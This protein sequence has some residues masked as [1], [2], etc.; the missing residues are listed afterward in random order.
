MTS[1]PVSAVTNL[2]TP[3]LAPRYIGPFNVIK[4]NEDAAQLD[5]PST[6]RLHP[7]FYVGRLK[8]YWPAVL[9]STTDQEQVHNAI[10]GKAEVLSDRAGV[11][12][13][14][15]RCPVE[16]RHLIVPNARAL[17]ETSNRKRSLLCETLC[18]LSHLPCLTCIMVEERHP[19][20]NC[21]ELLLD[22]RPQYQSLGL[23][24]L[25]LL[26]RAMSHHRWWIALETDVG[27]LEEY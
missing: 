25:T 1:I 5:I 24:C 27:W 19:S 26:S 23:R 21:L 12:R 10:L 6:M 9:P 17:S 15:P 11:A 14:T 3:K 8:R 18:S 16:E 4:V 7:T 20:I 22:R 2:G 13:A